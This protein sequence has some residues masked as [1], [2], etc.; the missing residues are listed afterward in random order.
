MTSLTDSSSLAGK[1]F[2]RAAT[3]YIKPALS[4]CGFYKYLETEEDI[5]ADEVREDLIM[6]LINEVIRT[7]HKSF[8]YEY[9]TLATRPNTGSDFLRDMKHKLVSY[10]FSLGVMRLSTDS[11][12]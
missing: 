5:K 10:T 8:F 4:A 2:I 7:Q 11:S 6:F 12:N 3:P 9:R 1:A